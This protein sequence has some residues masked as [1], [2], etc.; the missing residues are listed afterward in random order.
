MR[1]LF[2]NRYGNF[3]SL[4][5][6]YSVLFEYQLAKTASTIFR[7][8]SSYFFWYFKTSKMTE[9]RAYRQLE[10]QIAEKQAQQGD[11]LTKAILEIEKELED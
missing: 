9:F 5:D 10:G 8:D 4:F 7:F 11:E 2:Y 3:M 6:D 1:R